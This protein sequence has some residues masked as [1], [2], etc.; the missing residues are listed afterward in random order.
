MTE[1]TGAIFPDCQVAVDE[2]EYAGSPGAVQL[3]RRLHAR[4]QEIAET[5]A[6][7]CLGRTA[8]IIDDGSRSVGDYRD[9]I[10]R[11]LVLALIMPN[12]LALDLDDGFADTGHRL[13]RNL[14]YVGDDRAVSL[15]RDRSAEQ[16][17]PGVRLVRLDPSAPRDWV[18]QAQAL[19]NACG[20]VPCPGWMLRGQDGV[21]S[22]ILVMNEDNK[23]VGLGCATALSGMSDALADT[24]HLGSLSVDREWRGQGLAGLIQAAMIADV[25]ERYGVR[26]LI[27]G[28]HADNTP[29]RRLIETS[30]L[31]QDDTRSM[32]LVLH[33]DIVVVA[34][35]E[36][37]RLGPPG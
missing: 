10:E 37:V 29:S 3:Q 20:V 31:R 8:M 24:A 12:T 1:T 36:K 7:G 34:E 21:S 28:V 32:R 14:I 27:E 6:M 5:P 16:P 19:N 22:T 11:E 15:A 35:T 4:L 26:R 33:R 18:A 23:V 13:T 17:P 30:G 9:L 25:A 2:G